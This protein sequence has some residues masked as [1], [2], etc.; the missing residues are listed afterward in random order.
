MNGVLLVALASF[1]LGSIPFGVLFAHLFG[2]EDVRKKGSGNIGATNV[3]R[4]VGFWPAGFLTFLCDA[5]KGTVAVLL[6]GDSASSILQGFAIFSNPE[7]APGNLLLRWMAAACVVAGHCFSP[8]LRFRGGKGVATGFGAFAL[9]SPWASLVG[10]LG[11]ALAFLNTRIGSLASLSGLLLLVTAHVVLPGFVV[12]AHLVW[13]G[14]LVFI[15]LARH[16]KNLDALLE[17]RENR[18]E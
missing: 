10:I 4:V 3:S 5:L 12:G 14:V 7:W 8:W 16:E 6:A 1:L 11:F 9:L 13:G 15:V 18:F 17:S 2:G